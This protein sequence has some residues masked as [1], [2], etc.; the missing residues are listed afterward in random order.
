MD[1]KEAVVQPSNKNIFDKIKAEFIS[2][3]PRNYMGELELNGNCCVFSL[4][5]ILKTINKYQTMEE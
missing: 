3:Y 4:N 2:K 1:R 5:E